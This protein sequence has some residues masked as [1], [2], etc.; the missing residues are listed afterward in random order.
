MTNDKK[1]FGNQCGVCRGGHPDI[2]NR[3]LRIH[4]VRSPFREVVVG[5]IQPI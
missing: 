2:R 5:F 3:D 4:D 1:A